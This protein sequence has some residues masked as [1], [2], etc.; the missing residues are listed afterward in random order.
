MADDKTKKAP[1]DSSK[2]N[3]H[4]DYEVQYWTKRFGVSADV[5]KETVQKVGVSA[6]AVKRA[7]AK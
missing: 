3:I 2:I 7:L 4:E 6:E 1:Q 5:L